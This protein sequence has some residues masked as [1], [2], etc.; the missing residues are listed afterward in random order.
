MLELV[1]VS[2]GVGLDAIVVARMVEDNSKLLGDAKLDISVAE[3]V[4]TDKT[5]L[6]VEEVEKAR[7]DVVDGLPKL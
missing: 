7:V 1:V 2:R 4:W 5:E 6:G 3:I